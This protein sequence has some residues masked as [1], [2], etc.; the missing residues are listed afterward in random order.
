MD[1]LEDPKITN[2]D[3]HRIFKEILIPYVKPEVI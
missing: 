2:N 1:E 3:F